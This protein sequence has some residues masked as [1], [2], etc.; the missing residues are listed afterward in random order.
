MKKV[1]GLFIAALAAATVFTSCTKDEDKLGPE[2]KYIEFNGADQEITLGEGV[3]IE[4]TVVAGDGKLV[5]GDLKVTVKNEAGESLGSDNYDF[6]DEQDT[7]KKGLIAGFEYFPANVGVYTV[8]FDVSDSND[9]TASRSFKITVKSGEVSFDKEVTTGVIWHAQGPNKGAWDL[10]TDKEM[11]SSET[12]SIQ[13]L[14]AAGITF[15]GKFESEDGTLFV[16][17]AGDYATMSKTAAI[18]AYAAGTSVSKVD[19]PKKDDLFVAKKG[20]TYFLILITSVD[21]AAV[22][23][24]SSN[25]GKMTFTYKK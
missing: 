21:A 15:T 1:K 5:P 10:V 8:T 4:L 24:T 23:G 9:K 18:A 19:A 12:A 16:K 3:E 13:N 2:I 14:D 11:S 17:V 7:D 20:D 6:E 22:A 25:T